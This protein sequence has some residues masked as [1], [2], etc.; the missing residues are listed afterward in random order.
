MFKKIISA[1][2]YQ[3]ISALVRNGLIAGGAYLQGAA[4][5]TPE[6]VASLETAAMV[7]LGIAWSFARKQWPDLK[8]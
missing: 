6:Q 4:L 3:Y 8:L 7:V 2:L 1:K 5:A